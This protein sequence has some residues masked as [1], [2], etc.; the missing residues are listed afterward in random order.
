VGAAA[1]WLDIADCV[2]CKTIAVASSSNAAL[3]ASNAGGAV[4]VSPSEQ[5]II[6]SRARRSNKVFDFFSK[7]ENMKNSFYSVEKR[8]HEFIVQQKCPL[9]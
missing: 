2:S 4:V 5:A 1:G 7:N 8:L 6:K 9:F 3:V